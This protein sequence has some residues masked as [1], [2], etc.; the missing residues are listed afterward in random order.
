MSA[1]SVTRDDNSSPV[2]FHLN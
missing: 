1:D 2:W